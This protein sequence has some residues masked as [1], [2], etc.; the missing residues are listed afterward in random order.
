MDEYDLSEENSFVNFKILEE[1]F[2]EIIGPIGS[3]ESVLEKLSEKVIRTVI[4]P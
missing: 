3:N 1:D 2:D 4:S